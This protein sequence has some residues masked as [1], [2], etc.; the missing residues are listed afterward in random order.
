MF[1]GLSSVQSLCLLI[2]VKW[3]HFIQL[4]SWI[5]FIVAHGN[6]YDLLAAIIMEVR[7]VLNTAHLLVYSPANQ[8]SHGMPWDAMGMAHWFTAE[9]CWCSAVPRGYWRGSILEFQRWLLEVP[10]RSSCCRYADPFLIIG[11]GHI[12]LRHVTRLKIKKR[13]ALGEANKM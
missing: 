9:T 11:A 7:R 5:I 13:T 1:G 6:S 12:G 2:I 8:H 10:K 4:F 3:D